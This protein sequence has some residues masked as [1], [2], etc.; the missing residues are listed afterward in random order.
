MS[1]ANTLTMSDELYRAVYFATTLKLGQ[2]H[3]NEVCLTKK[4]AFCYT[5]SGRGSGYGRERIGSGGLICLL[6]GE[7]SCSMTGG[8]AIR[9]E[10][11]KVSVS[12]EK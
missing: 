7:R 8:R 12:I 3:H 5:P 2:W 4:T 1:L 11:V 10:K 9:L 6:R